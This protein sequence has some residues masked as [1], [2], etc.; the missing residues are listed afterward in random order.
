M[1]Q[2]L[3]TNAVTVT[4]GATRLLASNKDAEF[5]SIANGAA[6]LYIGAAAVTSGNGYSMAASTVLTMAGGDDRHSG[7]YSGELWGVVT[8][9][10]LVV[11]VLEAQSP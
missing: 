10:T 4:T 8:T 11:R 6:I 5:R 1:A 3:Y 7:I 2:L 9:G